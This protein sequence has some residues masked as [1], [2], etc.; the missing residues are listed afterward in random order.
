[1]VPRAGVIFAPLT[2]RNRLRGSGG[3]EPQ[4]VAFV[5]AGDEAVTADAVLD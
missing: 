5:P 3:D 1:M 2:Q 4:E